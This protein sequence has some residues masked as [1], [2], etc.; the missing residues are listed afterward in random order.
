M[1]LPY[2]PNWGYD[3]GEDELFERIHDLED[4]IRKVVT[5]QADDVC[6]ADAYIELGKL[7]GLEV[8][9]ESLKLLPEHKFRKNCDYFATCLYNNL[10]YS[11]PEK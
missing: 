3:Y 4:A 1:T 2:N 7:V 9:W 11:A 10:P 5:Q 6:W 8:T